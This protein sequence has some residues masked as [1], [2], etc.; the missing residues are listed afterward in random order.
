MTEEQIQPILNDAF[1]FW[2]IRRC[3]RMLDCN[4][5]RAEVIVQDVY[6]ALWKTDRFDPSKSNIVTYACWRL[7]GIV[8]IQLDYESR[9]IRTCHLSDVVLAIHGDDTIHESRDWLNID[10]KM[11]KVREFAAWGLTPTQRASVFETFIEGKL[12]K[13]VAQQ[14]GHTR[15]AVH[16]SRKHGMEKL[17]MQFA[18]A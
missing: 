15:Q 4:R 18:P 5:D 8:A 16:E 6:L 14:H 13:E 1:R 3:I 9:R 7:R 10:N 12:L 17:Q 2:M 11:Q